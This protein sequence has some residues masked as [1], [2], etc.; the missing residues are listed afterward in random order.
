[1]FLGASNRVDVQ[2]GDDLLSLLLKNDGQIRV[3]Q[4]GEQIEI[5]WDSKYESQVN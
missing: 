5:S 3:P 1:M 2:V 4:I